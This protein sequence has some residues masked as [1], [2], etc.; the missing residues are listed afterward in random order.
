MTELATVLLPQLVMNVGD[1][2]YWNG[3]CDTNDPR[4]HATFEVPFA[5]VSLQ[6]PWFMVLGNHDVDVYTADDQK[7]LNTTSPC[8]S[9]A[10]QVNYTASPASSGKWQLPAE[11]YYIRYTVSGTTATVLAIFLDTNQLVDVCSSKNPQLIWLEGLLSS[12]EDD[13]VFVLGHHAVYSLGDHG[14][15]PCVKNFTEPMFIQ[16][17]VSAYIGGHDH[18]LQHFASRNISGSL[19][20]P[21]TAHLVHYIQTGA[22]HGIDQPVNFSTADPEDLYYYQLC[23]PTN[24]FLWPAQNGYTAAELVPNQDAFPRTVPD[25]GADRGGFMTVELNADCLCLQAWDSTGDQLYATTI[26]NYRRAVADATCASF[27]AQYNSNL[28]GRRASS[29]MLAWWAWLLVIL[30]PYGALA[31][32][33][34]SLLRKRRR[35]SAGY[36]PAGNISITSSRNDGVGYVVLEK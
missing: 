6:M 20:S 21:P 3:V 18:R 11:W 8:G 17:K 25:S 1:N 9:I 15:V 36:I 30:L 4:F 14:P 31:L 12:S 16:Y 10:A 27:C 28:L 5:D 13:W 24:L 2:F 33:L 22:F 7:L 34:F 32:V 35:A 26:G 19:T 23:F 29:T